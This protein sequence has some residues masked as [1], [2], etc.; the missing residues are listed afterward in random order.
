MVFES[1]HSPFDPPAPF[2]RMYDNF[3]IPAPIRGEWVDG[4]DDP[5]YLRAKRLVGKWGRL[6]DEV[7]AESRR[8]YYG[9]VSHI[10]YEL[11][12]FLGELRAR[13]LDD[14]TAIIFRRPRR[15]S[16]RPRPL[17]QT[18][19]LTGS[20]CLS[21][22]APP[23]CR[24]RADAGFRRPHP[25]RRPLPTVLELAGLTEDELD[26]ISCCRPS[27]QELPAR[28]IC[29]DAAKATTPHSPRICGSI[30]L[31]HARRH[32]ASCS[33]CRPTTKPAQPG[34]RPAHAERKHQAHLLAYLQRFERPLVVDG[35][36]SSPTHAGRASAPRAT[37]E[38]ARPMRYGQGWRRMVAGENQPGG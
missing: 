28:V 33:T 19:F 11:G 20:D 32:R 1:P 5:A 24:C 8:R 16:G 29:G 4:P 38:L 2:D 21:S 25:Y 12:R 10:D 13:G 26:G 30:H 22:C 7:I 9:L 34:I 27:V 15:A 31:L 36:S 37:P 6:S 14:N 18:T 35:S 3:T 23:N 17:R